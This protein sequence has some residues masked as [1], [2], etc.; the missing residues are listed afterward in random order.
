MRHKGGDNA[1]LGSD[2]I[3]ERNEDKAREKYQELCLT[4]MAIHDTEALKRRAAD[5]SPE[6]AARQYLK[7]LDL[8]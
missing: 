1:P 4:P 2:T 7:A 8:K 5:F 3:N 6:V